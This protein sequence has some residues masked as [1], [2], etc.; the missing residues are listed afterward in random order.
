MGS[1]ISP[2]IF[3]ACLWRPWTYLCL[4]LKSM[5]V[6]RSCSCTVSRW[7]CRSCVPQ[8]LCHGNPLLL[9]VSLFFFREKSWCLAFP[10][11][12]SS[13]YFCVF[14]FCEG[15]TVPGHRVPCTPSVLY[16]AKSPLMNEDSY[17][18][19]VTQKVQPGLVLGALE[20]FHSTD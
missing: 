6:L 12:L 17:F 16:H 5:N 3:M 1:L 4:S 13:K 7:S 18:Y 8:A 9:S 19:F 14:A 15:I 11:L 10:L 20:S 2:M